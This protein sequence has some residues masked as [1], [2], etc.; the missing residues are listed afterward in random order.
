[1]P[2]SETIQ[3]FALQGPF[4]VAQLAG[5]G[6]AL[7][8]VL[9]WLAW[10]WARDSGSWKKS[11][12]LLLLRLGALAVA[13]WMLAGASTVTLRRDTRAKSLV[14]MVDSSASM[15]L[16]DPVDGSG[17][18]V[19][20]TGTETKLRAAPPVAAL[21]EVIGT[22]Q[23][24]RSD[25]ARLRVLTE[26][27]DPDQ[28][29][30]IL[31]EQIH[32]SV[33]SAAASLRPAGLPGD[34]RRSRG[35]RGTGAR[36]RLSQGRRQPDGFL[37]KDSGG[38]SPEDRLDETGAFITAAIQRIE[39]QSH[40]LAAAYEKDAAGQDEPALALESKMSRNDKVAG[41]LDAA[42]NSWLKEVADH[43]SIERYTFCFRGAWPWPATIGARSC[44]P[45]T[46][47]PPVPPIWPPPLTASPSTPPSNPWTPSS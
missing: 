5:L 15:G 6:L 12:S 45:T 11:A 43:A 36:R 28:R 39:R 38:Q 32:R 22:L 3:K 7:A 33:D 16:V 10:R 44:A 41:W 27:G 9:A 46:T 42:E 19:R 25:A 13:L 23:S 20:W 47:R 26:G 2:H 4:S 17:E 40:K 14:F 29:G 24:A 8:A 35:G 21:D 18:T 37:E 34:P 31:W 30:Q 1:M